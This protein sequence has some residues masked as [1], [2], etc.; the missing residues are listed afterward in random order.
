MDPESPDRKYRGFEQLDLLTTVPEDAPQA[1][2]AATTTLEAPSGHPPARR[3]RGRPLGPSARS[4]DPD[5]SHLS[6]ERVKHKRYPRALEI[7]EAYR[8]GS[9]LGDEE[10][11]IRTGSI[12][13]DPCWWRS[14][15]DARKLGWIADTG[16]RG[17][18]SNGSTVMLCA[19]TD[20]GR[21][22]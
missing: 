12:V 9:A 19:I 4:S 20:A 15:S 5:T 16:K 14:C 2:P 21:A 8:D 13:N 7:L 11:A 18:N 17:T 22:Q 6:S 1:S 10:A 3:G